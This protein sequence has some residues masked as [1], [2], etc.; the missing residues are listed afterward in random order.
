MAA[1]FIPRMEWSFYKS[2]LLKSD[3]IPVGIIIVCS[4]ESHLTY[5]ILL[6]DLILQVIKTVR[7]KRESD[8]SITNVC[9][10]ES[11]PASINPTPTIASGDTI[12]SAMKYINMPATDVI[13][14]FITKEA[15]RGH[16]YREIMENWSLTAEDIKS[17][18][19]RIDNSTEEPFVTYIDVRKC[20]NPDHNN[21]VCITYD[22][23]FSTR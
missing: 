5:K 22:N 2:A 21:K 23:F 17:I 11:D 19:A 7:V 3:K 9:G 15:K 13:G 16:A 4:Y 14:V 12:S 18:Q 8:G 6:N 20:T 1:I 10:L